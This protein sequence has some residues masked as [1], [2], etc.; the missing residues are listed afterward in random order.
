M[1]YKV[2]VV[3]WI[4]LFNDLLF[5]SFFI[6]T[7]QSTWFSQI[8]DHTLFSHHVAFL[9]VS[10]SHILLWCIIQTKC[11][12][13]S[14]DSF[15]DQNSVLFYIF[16]YFYNMPSRK[17]WPDRIS[18]WIYQELLPNLFERGWSWKTLFSAFLNVLVW[19]FFFSAW[20]LAVY[21]CLSHLKKTDVLPLCTQPKSRLV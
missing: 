2:T 5:S 8:F 1:S 7:F 19:F 10:T 6:F 20:K 12:F 11:L 13:A 14:W 9:S 16:A 3:I 17:A 18:V 21:H 4:F 15:W